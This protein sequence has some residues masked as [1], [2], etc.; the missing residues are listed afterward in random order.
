MINAV[1]PCLEK[2]TR[3]FRPNKPLPPKHFSALDYTDRTNDSHPDSPT[4]DSH[5]DSPTNNSNSH[6]PD[7][8]SSFSGEH[9]KVVTIPPAFSQQAHPQNLT[10]S[11]CISG[12]YHILN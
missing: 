11:R 9:N 10:I 6:S 3:L 12:R 8:L 4:N 1:C 2:I 5:P 7:F